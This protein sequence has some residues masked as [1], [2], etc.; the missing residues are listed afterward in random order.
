MTIERVTVTAVLV[1]L[2]GATVACTT[3][4]DAAV[5]LVRVYAEKDLQ[6]ASD[7]IQ[8]HGM[9][10]GR[11]R[12]TGCGRTAVYD[13]ACEGLQCRVSNEDEEAPA[14]RDRPDP[15]STEFNR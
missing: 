9:I 7:Q 8:V 2:A 13:T 1:A 11:Y 14:W 4:K 12:A 5:P 6:C 15:D 10:G 3:T